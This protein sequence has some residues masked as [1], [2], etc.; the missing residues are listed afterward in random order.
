MVV[1]MVMRHIEQGLDDVE[2]RNAMDGA[3]SMQE[4]RAV[5][6]RMMTATNMAQ[7]RAIRRSFIQ[8]E[9]QEARFWL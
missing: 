5:R 1:R 8:P 3:V 6:H 4:I 7:P 9:F 2:I